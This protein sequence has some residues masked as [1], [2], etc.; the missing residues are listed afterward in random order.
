VIKMENLIIKN[1][2]WILTKDAC[3]YIWYNLERIAAGKREIKDFAFECKGKNYHKSSKRNKITVRI[4]FQNTKDCFG[5]TEF[6]GSKNIYI[7]LFLPAIFGSTGLNKVLN[8]KNVKKIISER[9]EENI[10]SL[11]RTFSHELVHGYD[12]LFLNKKE[13]NIYDRTCSELRGKEY[14]SYYYN[15]PIEKKAHLGELEVYLRFKRNNAVSYKDLKSRLN[16]MKSNPLKCNL[17]LYEE[18]ISKYQKDQ[19]LEYLKY[20]EKVLDILFSDDKYIKI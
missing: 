14:Y 9:S 19:W 15:H 16:K 4:F 5:E 7:N 10:L 18:F 11:I 2:M 13:I 6:S 17:S 20:G 12:D 8:K 3:S 1:Y